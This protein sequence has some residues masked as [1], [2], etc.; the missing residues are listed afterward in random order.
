MTVSPFA[1]FVDQNVLLP[2]SGFFRF[3]VI[4]YF[5][6]SGTWAIS[7][8]GCFRRPSMMPAILSIPL[9][10]RELKLSTSVQ[11]TAILGIDLFRVSVSESLML[12]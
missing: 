11:V 3:L 6:N 10:L 9:R 8:S 4:G 12:L 1:Q 2:E 7:V 5:D